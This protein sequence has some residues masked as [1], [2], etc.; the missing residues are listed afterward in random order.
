MPKPLE[1]RVKPTGHVTTIYDTFVMESG[2]QVQ[3]E[4]D[5]VLREFDKKFMNTVAAHYSHQ[6]SFDGFAFY[7]R[8]TPGRILFNNLIYENLLL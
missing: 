4:G 8:T 2:V 6:T 7:I 3:T 1:I 5:L